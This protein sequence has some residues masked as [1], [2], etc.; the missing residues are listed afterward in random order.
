[1]ALEDLQSNYGPFNKKGKPGT[2]ESVDTL[3]GEG[4]KNRGVEGIRSKYAGSEKVGKKPTGPDPFG[5]IPAERS[6]E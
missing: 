4:I 6:F 1:M 5:N 2:G 3:A